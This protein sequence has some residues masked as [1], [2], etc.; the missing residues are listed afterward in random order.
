MTNVNGITRIVREA[1]L[2]WVPI[3]KMKVN[4]LAQR[5]INPARVDHLAADLNL[6]DLG[7]PTV[8]ERDGHFYLIDGYHR[9]EALKQV[10][11]GD[12]QIQCWTYVGLTEDQEA[13]KFRKLND[14][15]TVTA[16]DRF[17]IGVTA[18]YPDETEIDRIVRAQGLVVSREKVPGAIGAVG[19]LQSVF[20]SGA[21]TL[22]R[23]LRIIRDAY[24]DGGYDANV[25]KG[26][27]M[28]C[29]RYNG[30]LDDTV[31]VDRLAAA[32]G[33][34]NGLLNKAGKLNFQ[35][36]ESRPKCVAAA[37]VDTINGNRRGKKALPSWWKAAEA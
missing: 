15:L 30:T 2:R 32:H 37:A 25:I 1:R 14:T 10:G 29:A 26:I 13:D 11:W 12:Q 22:A 33:G 18:G 23:T 28:L 21:P 19:A 4:P 24:G 3:A 35:T 8:N 7:T 9:V 34:V 36:G 27:G 20:R 6:E 5:D 31:A 16:F 17:K